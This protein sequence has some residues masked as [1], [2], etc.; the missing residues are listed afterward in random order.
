MTR[1][2]AVAVLAVIMAVI[3]LRAQPRSLDIRSSR[4]TVYAYRAGIFGGLGDN[5]EI[6][7]PITEGS[8]DE[9]ARR[10]TLRFDARQMR[11][12]DPKLSAE[13]RG[14][15]QQRMLGPDVLDVQRFPDITFESN[16]IREGNHGDLS[17]SGT[18]NLHGHTHA[19]MGTAMRTS[20]GYHG[21][22]RLSQRDFGIKPVSIAGGTVKVKDELSIEFEVRPTAAK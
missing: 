9:S 5:H 11:V 7:A 3:S 2:F 19:V 22:F 21:A 8:L 18:L 6:S 15:V 13:K 10:I 14:E 16:S 4:V 1:T 20:D 17:I 12:L